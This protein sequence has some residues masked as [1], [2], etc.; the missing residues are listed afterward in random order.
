MRSAVQF[1]PYTLLVR[2]GLAWTYFCNRQVE[3]AIEVIEK[4][5]DEF[6]RDSA[7]HGYLGVFSAFQ[8]LHTQA[9]EAGNTAM[10]L[11]PD[12]PIA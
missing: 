7:S 12:T 11:E 9:L 5:I 2:H 4:V 6:P 8:R 3:T 10:A 1:D